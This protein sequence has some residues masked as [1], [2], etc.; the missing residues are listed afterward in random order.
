MPP[1]QLQRISFLWVLF[2]YGMLWLLNLGTLPIA[3]VD[4]VL[5]LDPVMN[6]INGEGYRSM[7]WPY[8]GSDQIFMAN[9]P[10]RNLPYWIPLS[11]IGPHIMAV[12]ALHLIAWLGTFFFSYKVFCFWVR[13]QWALVILVFFA[14]DPGIASAMRAVRPE[15]WVMLFFTGS[16]YFMLVKQQYAASMWLAWLLF[17]TH[18]A[19]WPLS[20]IIVGAL[21]L[22]PGF[23]S[24][25]QNRVN[26]I[27]MIVLSA[28]IIGLILRHWEG[29]QDQ[30]L[31]A[32]SDHSSL[33]NRSIVTVF[34]DHFIT[35]FAGYL[36]IHIYVLIAVWIAHAIALYQVLQSIMKKE[37]LPIISVLLLAI[38]LFWMGVLAP[39][40]RYNAPLIWLCFAQIAVMI[41]HYR[42][43]WHGITI[44]GL[45]HSAYTLLL[46]IVALL[47][48]PARNP[49][50][51]QKWLHKS[52]V[53]GP[54]TLVC[55]ESIAWYAR[56]SI[57]PKSQQ[58]DYCEP[59]YP[60]HF[61][62][63][64]YQE[65]YILTY[66]QLDSLPL[67]SSYSP[68]PYPSWFRSLSSYLPQSTTYSGLKLYK[69]KPQDVTAYCLQKRN[70]DVW[71][72]YHVSMP[73]L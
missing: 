35:R 19:A 48:Y 2:L 38:S 21:F 6:R 11:F 37:R 64:Q 34:Q 40:S 23:W 16:L 59:N 12:R 51:A 32:G 62:F 60:H 71:P 49:G 5:D 43:R 63:N 39:H 22:K 53:G 52:G 24:S 73:K 29:F 65:L 18:P 10:F 54:H 72:Q 58:F 41:W 28:P 36:G 68:P 1:K 33:Q 56:Q 50:A 47:Q 55:G 25:K 27:G 14:L 61:D 20:A 30:F 44:L 46:L 3:W 13:P 67:V 42:V 26:L 69:A 31:S 9:L 15:T 17:W 57:T 4:E 45:Y 70:G 8:L 66:E 7:L